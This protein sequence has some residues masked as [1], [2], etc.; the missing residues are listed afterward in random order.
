M[1]SIS[2][3]LK[4]IENVAAGRPSSRDGLVVNSW[5]RCLNEYRLD[6]SQRGNAYIVPGAKLREHQ[7]QAE[8]LIRISRAAL[9][10]LYEQVA[11]HNYVLLLSDARGVSVAHYRN[12]KLDPALRDAGLYLGADWA[13]DRT[14]TCAVGA[15]L[16]SRQ[17]ITVHQDDHFDP[18]HIGLTC[19]AAPVFDTLGELVAVVDISQLRSAVPRSSQQLARH[20]VIATARRVELANLMSQAE[21]HWLLRLSRSPDFIDSDPEAAL[22][23]DGDGRI[24]GMTHAAFTALSQRIGLTE[25]SGTALIGQPIDTLFD[26]DA[27]TLDQYRRGQSARDRILYAGGQPRLFASAEPPATRAPRTIR[28]PVAEPRADMPAS[29]ARLTGGDETM[30]RLARRAARFA[31]RDLP[32]LIQGETGTGKEVLA[33][34]VHA[35]RSHPGPFVAVNCAAIPEH[36]IESELFGYA[37][38]AFTGAARGGKRGL[39]EAAH[40]GTLFLDEIGDMPLALQSRLLRVLAERCVTPVG[41]LESRPV[42]IHLISATHAPLADRVAR[43][44]FRE[45]LYYRLNAAVLKLPPLRERADFDALADTILDEIGA[46]HG[47]RY[48]LSRAA[49]RRLAAH[50]WPGNVRELR[51]ALSVA[52]ALCEPPTIEVDDLPDEIGASTGRIGLEAQLAEC[53]G[54]V[55]E[56]ARRLGVDRT[57]V[58]RRLKRLRT[59]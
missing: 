25:H 34:A 38:N 21:G 12:P 18:A 54:N 7:Q 6:P 2:A 45:D 8:E 29:L 33:R 39:I 23:V 48:Q 10:H 13:E 31:Q 17:P 22:A 35:A 44:E 9:D 50:H 28:R 55:S 3:H 46:E 26:L 53:G 51:N 41:A 37:P 36:L 20:L 40:G 59:H 11:G 47:E 14:G 15:A 30:T 56:L 52:T 58:H 43:G 32:V 24:R 19:S 1:S 42:A 4:E 16:V 57:T 5:L 49:R 27:D